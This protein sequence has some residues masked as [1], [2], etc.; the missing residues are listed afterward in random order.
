MGALAQKSTFC[1]HTQTHRALTRK[2]SLLI[3]RCMRGGFRLCRNARPLAA[4]IAN[5]RRVTHGSCGSVSNTCC[6]KKME[7][8][9]NDDYHFSGAAAV[10][11]L[12]LLN[13]VCYFFVRV[14]V[15]RRFFFAYSSLPTPTHVSP[16]YVRHLRSL[17]VLVATLFNTTYVSPCYSSPRACHCSPLL[18]LCQLLP[19]LL[20]ELVMPPTLPQVLPCCVSCSLFFAYVSLP[21]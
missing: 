6:Q 10:R 21:A 7:M 12:L 17:R 14:D 5:R 15:T 16:C 3:S 13:C 9:K 18:M 4:S 20:C 11:T 8:T 2:F 19:S 1:A